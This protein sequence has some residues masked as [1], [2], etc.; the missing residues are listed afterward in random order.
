MPDSTKN[1]RDTKQ[2]RLIYDTVQKRHDHPSADDIYA[3]VHQIDPKISKATVYRNLKLLAENGEITH[4]KMPE[5]DR[6]DFTLDRHSHIH[7]T[8]C[9]A[10][11]DAPIP[12]GAEN[13]AIVAEKTGYRI[14]RHQTVFE[15]I[16]PDCLKKQ[17]KS[18]F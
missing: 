15:G 18:D 2:R 6:F 7:C 14:V 17:S 9:G 11:I 1:Q 13:D 12:Y 10:V 5:A 4:V 8:V 16:C 3:D